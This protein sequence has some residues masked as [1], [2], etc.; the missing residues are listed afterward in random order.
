MTLMQLLFFYF[1]V[2]FVDGCTLVLS[3]NFIREVSFSY[4][5]MLES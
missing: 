3:A 5:N 1:S 2:V 4:F